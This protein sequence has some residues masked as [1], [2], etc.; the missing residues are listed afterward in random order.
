MTN[1]EIDSIVATM[2][3]WLRKA[4]AMDGKKAILFLERK[5]NVGFPFRG[6]TDAIL[7][8]EQRIRSLVSYKR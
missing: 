5:H 4:S 7:Y 3:G 6:M 1:E 8:T 2:R